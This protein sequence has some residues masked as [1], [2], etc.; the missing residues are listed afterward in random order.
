[1]LLV[2]WD[3]DGGWRSR[4]EEVQKGKKSKIRKI[5]VM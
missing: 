5:K 1:M 2:L 4:D 3:D